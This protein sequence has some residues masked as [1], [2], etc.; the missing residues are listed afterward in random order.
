MPSFNF[1]LFPQMISFKAFPGSFSLGS[2][3]LLKMSQRTHHGGDFFFGILGFAV[4]KFYKIYP[5][6]CNI[7]ANAPENRSSAQ[8]EDQG[9]SSNHQSFRC[10]FLVSWRVPSN[11]NKE[12]SQPNEK[13]LES[14][15]TQKYTRPGVS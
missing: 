10:D 13:R 1:D 8:K 9:L 2:P 7:A 11:G 12:M 6:P 5:N 3:D 14:S 4:P 15:S